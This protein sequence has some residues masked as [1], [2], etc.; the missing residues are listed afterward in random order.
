MTIEQ[1]ILTILI[2]IIAA[3]PGLLALLMGRRKAT[4]DV[5]EKYQAMLNKAI[6]RIDTLEAEVAEYKQGVELLIE[7]LKDN[8]LKPCWE[9]RREPTRP[10]KEVE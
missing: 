3:L 10:R 4:A 6:L 1:T 5:A 9:P 8:G 7:Q 2:A